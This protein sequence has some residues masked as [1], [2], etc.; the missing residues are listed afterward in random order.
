MH[1]QDLDENVGQLAPL[2]MMEDGDIYIVNNFGVRRNE[3][4]GT[5]THVEFEN[6]IYDPEGNPINGIPILVEACKRA[7]GSMTPPKL[8][9]VSEKCSNI[10]ELYQTLDFKINTE[11]VLTKKEY[12]VDQP[13][14]PAPP[15]PV[16]VYRDVPVPAVCK[17]CGEEFKDVSAIDAFE[18]RQPLEYETF[19]RDHFVESLSG[20]YAIP[21]HHRMETT[22]AHGKKHSTPESMTGPDQPTLTTS[23]GRFIQRFDTQGQKHWIFQIPTSF[24]DDE[25]AY[26]VILYHKDGMGMP[27]PCYFQ[28]MVVDTQKTAPPVE[29]SKKNKF[30]FSCGPVGVY[31][32]GP[33]AAAAIIYFASRG[34]HASIP[35]HMPAPPTTPTFG[36]TVGSSNNNGSVGTAPG[37]SGGNSDDRGIGGSEGSLPTQP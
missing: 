37:A 4:D 34:G 12:V 30:H 9:Y 26:A 13:L 20:I 11:V 15:A 24:T 14:N 8:L 25:H 7:D 27:Q 5:H 16:I 18:N 23:H 32:W 29:I 19:D 35:V 17:S 10:L 6:Y 28:F 36:K 21:V 22:D 33:P 1:L 3:Q 2:P 31:C